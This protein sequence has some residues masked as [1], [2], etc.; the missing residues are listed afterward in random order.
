MHICPNGG[1]TNQIYSPVDWGC[2]LLYLALSYQCSEVNPGTSYYQSDSLSTIHCKKN[3]CSLQTRNSF[4]QTQQ[5]PSYLDCHRSS[6]LTTSCFFIPWECICM[7]VYLLV[8]KTSGPEFYSAPPPPPP[9]P[10]RNCVSIPYQPWEW[11]SGLPGTWWQCFWHCGKLL[12]RCWLQV[13]RE[14]E[15]GVYQDW[16]GGRVDWGGPHLS[17]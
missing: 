15:K 11:A 8:C 7:H 2:L 5:S 4:H 13:A 3:T 6:Q 9:P 1:R 12:L 10:P 14:R 16:P 17:T